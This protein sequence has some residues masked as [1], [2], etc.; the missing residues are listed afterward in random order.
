MAV[1]FLFINTYK[2]KEGQ[3]GAFREGFRQV[4]DLVEARQPRVLFFASYLD[5]EGTEAT[6]L[7]IHPDPESFENHMKL[8][9]EHIRGSVDSVDWSTMRIQLLGNMNETV[10]E[11]M[12]QVAG[13]GGQV[14]IKEPDS[15][16][17]RLLEPD[18]VTSEG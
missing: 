3:L 1:P 15:W 14:T 2:I 12:R 11:N 6:V 8:A 5:E 7:Q 17:D 16:V 13:S 10:L 18:S 9:A 4:L